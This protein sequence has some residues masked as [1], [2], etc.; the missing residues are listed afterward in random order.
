MA[1][2]RWMKAAEYRLEENQKREN[3]SELDSCWATHTTDSVVDGE[4]RHAQNLF[5]C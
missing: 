5:S 3:Q 4:L 2:E 1:M